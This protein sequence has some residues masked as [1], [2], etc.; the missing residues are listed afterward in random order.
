MNVSKYIKNEKINWICSIISIVISA[1]IYSLGVVLFIST[2]KLMAS[3]VSGVS[4]IIGRL[5][6]RA[7]LLSFNETQIAGVLY[8][9]LNIPILFLS[10][11]KFSLK[12]SILTIIHM[13]LTSLFTSLIDVNI[14]TNLLGVKSSW[15]LEHQLECALFAGVI[16]GFST[17][18][19]YLSGGSSAGSD[20][21]A[22]YLSDKKQ[23]SVGRIN[24]IVNGLIILISTLLW[25][26]DGELLNAFFTLIFIFVYA[27]VIDLIF[28][29]N[30]KVIVTIITE[31]GDEIANMINS[32]FTR[33]VT[34]IKAIG[35]YSKRDKDFLYTACTS[36][37]AL[38]I[39][40]LAVKIDEHS[41]TS[42]STAQRISG[43]FLNKYNRKS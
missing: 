10:F 43:Y 15:P 39:S 9:I 11:K 4:L 35:N 6:E 34:R 21:L 18:L 7:N 26:K 5:I 41:F 27:T 29:T 14:L 25:N 33:G 23:I 19:S 17:A 40:Q 38:E 13:V 31:K 12:F 30:K 37:E 16:C 32:K 3:G 24:A 1:F 22:A 28:V 20:V 36:M 8:F 2:A 42:I